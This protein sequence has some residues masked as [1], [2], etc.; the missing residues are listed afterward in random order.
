VITENSTEINHLLTK[1]YHKLFGNQLLNENL[2]V[3]ICE[4]VFKSLAVS[5]DKI[6]EKENFK[7]HQSF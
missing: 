5:A 7:I 4:E 6:K 3:N 1:I 2:L